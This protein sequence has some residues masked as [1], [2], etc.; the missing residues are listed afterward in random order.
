VT[1]ELAASQSHGFEAPEDPPWGSWRRRFAWAG[2]ARCR[3]APTHSVRWLTEW[4]DEAASR[5]RRTRF[6]FQKALRS[7]RSG[8]EAK[9]LQHFG[10]DS[11]E[12]WT[13][14]YSS[15][16]HPAVSASLP[17]VTL[18]ESHRLEKRVHPGKGLLPKSRT[19]PCQFLPS[20]KQE[21]LEATGLLGTQEPELSCWSSTG[22][23]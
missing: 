14:G 15:M 8:K 7:L 10:D 1:P 3:F 18:P 11:V 21:T 17:Q 23:T 2:S 13:S 5:G 16:E 20:P 22:S 12:C 4:R 6:V 19:L 9:I